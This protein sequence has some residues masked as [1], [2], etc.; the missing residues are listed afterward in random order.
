[1]VRADTC[2]LNHHRTLRLH[3]TVPHAGLLNKARA[4]S[5]SLSRCLSLDLSL[6]RCLSQSAMGTTSSGV[7]QYQ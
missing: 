7:N 6:S 1:M 5:F 2:R 3:A 4:L